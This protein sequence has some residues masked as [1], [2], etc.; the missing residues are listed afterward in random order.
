MARA[1][2][3]LLGQ[4]GWR[5]TLA[6]RNLES[7]S[8]TA[9]DL[10]IRTGAEVGTI[11]ADVA[12]LET[13]KRLI[14][15]AGHP[16]AV[17]IFAG[18]MTPE[19]GAQTPLSEMVAMMQTNYV[20]VCALLQTYAA[21]MTAAGKTGCL[22]AVS[23]VA[24]ERGRATNYVYGSSKA[25]LTVFLSGLRQA[26]CGTGIRVV[27]LIPGFVRTKMTE[28]MRL[29][30]FVTADAG[31]VA[32]AIK[33]ALFKGPDVVFVRGIWRW[34]MRIIRFIPESVFKRMRL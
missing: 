34:I 5:L 30:P 27:T 20:G 7:L 10:R 12:D 21:A 16:D 3:L 6:G 33:K 17:V 2:A 22:L 26:L 9:D 8:K 1:T 13:G 31:E 18:L 24:G 11:F 4:D 29:P 19:R 15:E 25:G 23:S 32:K 14:D 28:G